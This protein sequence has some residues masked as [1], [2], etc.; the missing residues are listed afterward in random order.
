M[1]TAAIENLEETIQDLKNQSP[2]VVLEK[3]KG[4]YNYCC[5]SKNIPAH[6]QSKGCPSEE[7]ANLKNKNAKFVDFIKHRDNSLTL[8]TS[9]KFYLKFLNR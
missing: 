4:L 2:K 3:A 5:W 7:I 1:R 6:L 8:I 9:D